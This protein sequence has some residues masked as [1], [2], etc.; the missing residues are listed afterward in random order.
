MQLIAYY[1]SVNRCDG[2]QEIT[3]GSFSPG[4]CTILAGQTVLYLDAENAW[5]VELVD[6]GDLK[7]PGH[8]PCG[9]ESRPRYQSYF[10]G[11]VI[12]WLALFLTR[13][14]DCARRCAQRI[15]QEL[16]HPGSGFF[17][18][19]GVDYIVAVKD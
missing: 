5:V 2:L 19:I 16:L 1:Q 12:F 18:V 15:I 17:E 6:T 14:M 8:S 3:E 10:K 13:D 7:S 4:L 11:L 9:F